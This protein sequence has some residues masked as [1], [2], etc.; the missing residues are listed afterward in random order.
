VVLSL[1]PSTN[2]HTNGH[3]HEEAPVLEEPVATYDL[4]RL[5]RALRFLGEARFGGLIT[6]LFAIRAFLPDEIEDA[7]E[8]ALHDV[9]ETLRETLDRLF[10]KL[11][12]PNYVIA[13]RDLETPA[14][15]AALGALLDSI[16]ASEAA[17]VRDRWWAAL[18]RLIP[19]NGDGLQ[20]YRT[21]LI[22]AIDDLPPV[23]EVAFIDALQRK[24]YPVLDAALDVVRAQIAARA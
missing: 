10:I 14:G 12:L 24:A 2:G 5:E 8:R 13:P 20:N 23:E 9:R 7:D 17:S 6:H 19:P 22:A 11:R 16:P 4:G 1:A 18:A 21:L 15:K 3:A